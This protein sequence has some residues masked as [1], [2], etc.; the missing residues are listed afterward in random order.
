MSNATQYQSPATSSATVAVAPPR[1]D[2]PAS[3]VGSRFKRVRSGGHVYWPETFGRKTYRGGEG[4]V[5]DSA[6]ELE[7][8]WCKGQEFRLE[9]APDATAA[10]PFDHPR[11]L[12]AIAALEQAKNPAPEPVRYQQPSGAPQARKPKQNFKETEGE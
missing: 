8:E 4:Y 10:T 2:P 6:I 3:W 7:R 1:E 11:A 9:D 12:H 5:I